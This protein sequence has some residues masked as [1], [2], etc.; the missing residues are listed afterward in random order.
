DGAPIESPRGKQGRVHIPGMIGG[1]EEKAALVVRSHSAHLRQQLV[2]DVAHRPVVLQVHPLL[3]DRVQLVE[4]EH[5]G[6]TATGVLENLV[7]SFFA[8]AKPHVE[9]IRESDAEKAR[10]QL[11]RGCPREKRL[12]ATRRAREAKTP[13]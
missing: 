12:A 11:A 13:A 7:Q 6:R 1:A 4:E 8:L 10:A 5:A 2:D 3:A 9:D